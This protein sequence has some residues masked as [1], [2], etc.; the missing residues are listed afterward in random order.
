MSNKVLVIYETRG[1][2]ALVFDN[3]TRL[4]AAE[5]KVNLATALAL[6]AICVAVF[7]LGVP[8]LAVYGH[9]I[10][11]VL[12]GAWR[13]LCGQRPTVD[14]FAQMGPLYYLL[15]AAGLAL[16]GGNA[17]GLGYSSA[18]AAVIIAGWAFL[19]LRRRMASLPF[20]LACL[21]LLLLAVAPF[22]LGH[23]PRE[24]SFSMKHNRY[25]F[26]LTGLVLLESFLPSLGESRRQ[27]F[28]GGFSS[29]LAC[30]ALLF[31][32]VSYGL[33]AIVIF[34][35][36]LLFRP[37]EH[38]RVA[39]ALAG[40]TVFA[41]PMLAY[42]RF[43]F[44][45]LVSEYRILAAVQKTRVSFY[46]ITHRFYFDR[47]QV[48]SILVLAI[49]TAALPDLPWR[50]R[51]ALPL[52]VCLAA[53]GGTLLILTNTQPDA[54]P[55]TSIAALLAINELTLYYRT[56]QVSQAPALL[57][58]G[59]LYVLSPLFMNAAGLT[60]GLWD[61]AFSPVPVHRFQAAHLRA[62]E[63]LDVADMRRRN[64]NGEAYVGYTEEGLELVRTHTRPGDT[65]RGL[66][67]S[68]PFSYALWRPPAE[69]GAVVISSTDVSTKAVAP[70]ELLVGDPDVLVVPKYEETERASL[71]ILLAKY[72]DLLGKDYLPVAESQNWILY[73]KAPAEA[74]PVA[75]QQS[76]DLQASR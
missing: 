36:S 44:G 7:F 13:V 31:L 45:A 70:K 47:Y 4:W 26:T 71:D 73:R 53:C 42:L 75:E 69:G 15:H 23:M 54:R 17:E 38:A 21:F 46:E 32:K 62:L 52:A 74:P 24:T 51:L 20:V 8:R 18:L 29:G 3:L 72:P 11:I 76:S 12:D 56:K 34:S 64:D 37:K 14:F 35:A 63:F 16:A 30:A 43:D 5:R 57:G 22:P 9:D 65:V 6:A 19:L 66:S 40:G 27:Q 68:N 33:V 28:G 2:L 41:L 59:L 49:F 25:G 39:G 10:F 50:R 1:K 58:F 60:L 48:G 67:M 61:K 55:L